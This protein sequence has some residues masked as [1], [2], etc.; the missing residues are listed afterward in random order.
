MMKCQKSSISEH[1]RKRSF[2]TKAQGL[3]L[4]T[5]IVAAVGL[6]VLVV[7]VAIFTGQIGTFT[8]GVS[9]AAKTELV[10]MQLD[11]D[12]CHPSRSMERTFLS[13][14]DGAE[15]ETEKAEIINQFDRAISSCGAQNQDICESHTPS[16]YT[17]MTCTWD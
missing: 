16:D 15:D 6:I 12:T 4:T 3:S 5:I 9:K 17:G 1:V 13:A 8:L 2:Q 10:T 11:Y 7:L 14:L